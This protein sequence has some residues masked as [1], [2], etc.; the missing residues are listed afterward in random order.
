MK[1]FQ[2]LSGKQRGGKCFF[3]FGEGEGRADSREVF[4]LRD[5]QSRK[6]RGVNRNKSGKILLMS[7]NWERA[8]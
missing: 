2:G 3:F 6:A 5:K 4:W 8:E 1:A 7:E